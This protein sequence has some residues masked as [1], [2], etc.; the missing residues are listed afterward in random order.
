MPTIDT[1]T[2]HNLLH[3]IYNV[4]SF[5]LILRHFRDT[6]PRTTYIC[7]NCRCEILHKIVH[8]ASDPSLCNKLGLI[9]LYNVLKDAGLTSS[10]NYGLDKSESRLPK[11]EAQDYMIALGNPE[12]WHNVLTRGWGA[13][14]VN[15]LM[16]KAGPGYSLAELEDMSKTELGD[17]V[18]KLVFLC[19]GSYSVVDLYH[20]RK[21]E[22]FAEWTAELLSN[23]QCATGKCE[24]LKWQQLVGKKNRQGLP[25]TVKSLDGEDAIVFARIVLFSVRSLLDPEICK[26]IDKYA[27]LVPHLE[28]E[29]DPRAVM[30]SAAKRYAWRPRRL[31][32]VVIR[33]AAEAFDLA[34]EKG[35]FNHL[36]QEGKQRWRAAKDLAE[37]EE[38]EEYNAW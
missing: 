14:L 15:Y 30:P 36:I 2:N 17:L 31:V 34:R 37:E 5:S 33:D 32:Q 28:K 18:T 29:F 10:S 16:G 21:F 38:R 11:P 26:V 7:H 6:N 20:D 23:M 35:Y 9:P 8:G 22:E 13:F 4:P 12:T 19:R 24:A 27:G 3:S 25:G 1:E